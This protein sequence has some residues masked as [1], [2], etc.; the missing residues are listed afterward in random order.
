MAESLYLINFRNHLMIFCVFILRSCTG[1]EL[2]IGTI[3]RLQ[4][5][6]EKLRLENEVD[7]VKALIENRKSDIFDD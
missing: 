7:E 6:F 2:R 5:Y 1:I 4:S 3:V